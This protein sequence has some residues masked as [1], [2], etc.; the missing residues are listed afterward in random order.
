MGSVFAVIKD[1]DGKIM[2]KH[3]SH[4]K[5]AKQIAAIYANEGRRAKR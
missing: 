5:A 4:A 1:A 3:P 2:G